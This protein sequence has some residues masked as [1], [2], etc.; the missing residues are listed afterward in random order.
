VQTQPRREIAKSF[1]VSATHHGF[2][3][4]KATLHRAAVYIDKRLCAVLEYMRSGA[5]PHDAMERLPCN[6]RK[7]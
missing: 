6:S 4:S 3:S 7:G 5:Y 1:G 2:L